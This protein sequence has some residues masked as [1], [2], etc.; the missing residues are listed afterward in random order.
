MMISKTCQVSS[1][2]QS[3]SN[4]EIHGRR[5]CDG[6]FSHITFQTEAAFRP[7]AIIGIGGWGANPIFLSRLLHFRLPA[8]YLA[9][10]SQFHNVP[11]AKNGP[12]KLHNFGLSINN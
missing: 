2:T 12:R 3:D 1:S 5:I 10:D 7:S 8:M 6:D 9:V 4:Y 11:S